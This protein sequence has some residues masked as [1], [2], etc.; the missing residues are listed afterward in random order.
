MGALGWFINY[1]WYYLFYQRVDLTKI[2]PLSAGTV[3]RSHA[4]I[5]AFG[6]SMLAL[7]LMFLLPPV[8]W[9]IASGGFVLTLFYP[10]L[11]RFTHFPQILLGFL[12]AGLPVLMG[13]AARQNTLSLTAWSACLIASCWPIAY[14]TLYAMQ[15]REDDNRIHVHSLAILLGPHVQITTLILQLLF[16]VGWFGLGFFLTLSI[17]YYIGWLVALSL[18]LVQWYII[19][20]D[21]NAYGQAFFLNAILGASL[22]L[23][24][25]LA[26]I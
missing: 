23:G 19:R 10:A 22:F 7:M 15:D 9:A 8:C 14:D 25:L 17:W 21:S 4:Y 20:Q 2:G 24:L 3:T 13:F 11:K 18:T 1:M 26:R 5:I 16:L 6:L 12:F